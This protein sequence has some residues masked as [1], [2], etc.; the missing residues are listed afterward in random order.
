MAQFRGTIQGQ[1]GE[2]SRL[3]GKN[4]GMVAVVNGWHL[5]VRVYAYHANGIDRIVVWR[6]GGSYNPVLDEVLAVIEDQGRITRSRS[7]SIIG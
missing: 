6:T 1:R 3:G 2:V 7:A 5:G 4:S